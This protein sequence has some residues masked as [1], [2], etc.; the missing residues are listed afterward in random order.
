[1]Q[2]LRFYAPKLLRNEKNRYLCK[3]KLKTKVNY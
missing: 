1:M 3:Q 2:F